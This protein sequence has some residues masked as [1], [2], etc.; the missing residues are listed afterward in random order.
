MNWKIILPLKFYH[1][2]HPLS[3][4]H[5]S[6]AGAQ[7]NTSLTDQHLLFTVLPETFGYTARI[8]CYWFMRYNIEKRAEIEQFCISV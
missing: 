7:N 8:E 5:S 1:Y 2:H 3:L 4:L 6:S